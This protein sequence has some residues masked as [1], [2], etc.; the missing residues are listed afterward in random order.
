MFDFQQELWDYC[1]SDVHLLKEGCLTFCRDFEVTAG[2][3]PMEHCL[4]I[5][6]ACNVAYRRNW[7]PKKMIAVEPLRGWRA[8]Q[9]QSK[10]ALEW[11]HVVNRDLN[12]QIVHAGNSGEVRL[13]HGADNFLVDGYVRETSTVYEF[14]GCFY[15]GCP[16]CFPN[17]Y[18]KH[19]KHFGLTMHDVTEDIQTSST[20]LHSC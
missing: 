3:N 6:S 4:T 20:Q 8:T 16:T 14:H 12:H 15:H 18:Q 7:M 9:Q 2:F 11:L 19:P 1:V 5:A 17:R 13:S 10:V